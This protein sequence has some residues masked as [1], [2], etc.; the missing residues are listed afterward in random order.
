MRFGWNWGITRVAAKALCVAAMLGAAQATPP[1]TRPTP[2]T[3]LEKPATAPPS[4]REDDAFE[5]ALR[6]RRFE[7]AE[8]LAEERITRGDRDPILLYNSACVLAQRGKLAAAEARLLQCVKAGF[9]D[10]DT[11]EEDPDLEPVRASMTYEA[12][13]EARHRVAERDGDTASKPSTRRDAPRAS[14]R[15][16]LPDPVAQWKLDHTEGYRYDDAAEGPFADSIVYATFLDEASHARMERMLDELGAHLLRAYFTKPPDD[17]LLVA[18]V[19]PEHAVKYLD[20]PEVRGMY[21]H[22]ARRLVSRDAGQ[23]LQHEFVHLLHFAAMERAGQRHPIWVQEGLASLYEDY[24]LRADG[25]VEFHPNVRFNLARRQVT[26][27]TAKHFAELFALSPD[28]FM[29]DAQR[30]YPQVR[31]IFEFFAREKKLE[32]FYRQLC[33]T[34]DDDPD[35]SNAVEKAFGQPL[36]RVEERWTAWMLERGAID[37]SIERHDASLGVSIEDAGDGVRIKSFVLKSAARAAGLR[38]GDVII[39]VDGT[40]IRNRDEMLIVVA[41]LRIDERITVRFRRD[42]KELT[43]QVTPRAL[44]Q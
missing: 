21:L 30:L 25:S 24:T 36:I 41:R 37:D 19:R 16:A 14:R 3:P 13:M 39:E 9:R 2:P 20:R 1:L 43:L 5:R 7:E 17:R 28:A 40:P 11:M 34:A 15:L 32:E 6:A 8:R 23:S 22:S 35:G 42:D 26:S 27:K 18:I 31:S 12:I 29:R 38:V 10:F 44:G 33:L 4:D